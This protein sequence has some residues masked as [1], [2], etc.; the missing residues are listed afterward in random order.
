MFYFS[1]VRQITD[2]EGD[3]YYQLHIDV[4]YEANGKNKLFHTTVWDKELNES[5][6]DYIRNSPDFAYA[7]STAYSEVEIYLEQA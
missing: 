5:I 6:F 1:L 3:K 4:L 2:D 7:K